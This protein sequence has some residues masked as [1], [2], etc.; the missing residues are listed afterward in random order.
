MSSSS[1]NKAC[2]A[3]LIF[4]SKLYIQ[5]YPVVAPCSWRAVKLVHSDSA[6][7]DVRH[8]R[9]GATDGS[10]STSN[11]EYSSSACVQM[12]MVSEPKVK[13]LTKSPFFG[14]SGSCP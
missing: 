12:Y 4:G 1:S 13:S 10:T 11:S 2:S 6:A 3:N 14:N 5:A 9:P 7:A 8:V